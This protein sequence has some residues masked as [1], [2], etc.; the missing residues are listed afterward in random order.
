M[1]IIISLA[2]PP[3]P[4]VLA[5]AAQWVEGALLGSFATALATIAVAW[6]GFLML[7]GR[8]EL[9][10]A[11]LVVLGCFILFGAS[12]IARGLRS[13]SDQIADRVTATPVLPPPPLPH[14][15]ASSPRPRPVF[16]DDPN[17]GVAVQR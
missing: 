4:G 6:V 11:L 15:R 9:R 16:G 17:A 5:P 3:D 7:T 14:A 1:S 2:T 8:I 10:R 12:T 13:A